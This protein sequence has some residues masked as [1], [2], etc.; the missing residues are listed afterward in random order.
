[1]TTS[2]RLFKDMRKE[3]SKNARTYS[4]N[5]LTRQRNLKLRN[6]TVRL[7]MMPREELSKILKMKETSR[8]QALKEKELFLK[9]RLAI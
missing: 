5:G 1:M 2:T 8:L 9:R 4:K 6:L 7:S 3:L